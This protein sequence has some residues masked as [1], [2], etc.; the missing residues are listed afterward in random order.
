MNDTVEMVNVLTEATSHMEISS[1]PLHD[2]IAGV[3]GAYFSSNES[4]PEKL[5]D[6]LL[7]MME[8]PFLKKI[9]EYTKGNQSWAAKILKISR[10]TL[11]KKLKLYDM[12]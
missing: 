1:A 7:G 9:M 2:E 4:K 3:L 11:R 10:G 12:L 5:Y 6:H 8:K